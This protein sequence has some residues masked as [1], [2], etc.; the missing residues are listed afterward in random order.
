M[1]CVCVYND[2]DY[3]LYIKHS[4]VFMVNTCGAQDVPLYSLTFFTQYIKQQIYIHLQHLDSFP[5]HGL[6]IL[7]Q[8]TSVTQSWIFFKGDQLLW[9]H[10]LLPHCSA[11]FLLAFLYLS[12]SDW[13]C[14]FHQKVV[15]WTTG[16][17]K[18]VSNIRWFWIGPVISDPHNN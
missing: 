5:Q 12:L 11:L 2:T 13:F 16:W 17:V 9:V 14:G 3:I 7:Q 1:Y 8:P 15:V 4:M 10:M 18:R 6:W